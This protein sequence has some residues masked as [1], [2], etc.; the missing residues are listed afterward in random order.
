MEEN[1]LAEL[2]KTS[3][4]KLGISQ[5]ELS[6]RTG[7]DNNSIS[8][9]EKGE[10]RKP[11]SL[12]LVKLSKV[13]NIDL[14]ELMNASGYTEEDI[15]FTRNLNDEDN[16]HVIKYV[17]TI[18]DLIADTENNIKEVKDLIHSIENSMKNHNDEAYK[19]M[20]SEDIVNAD[21]ISQSMIDMNKEILHIYEDK[22][23]SLK[24]QKK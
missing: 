2:V 21:K 3:R 20:S 19:N 10:R 12:S 5:R 4:E 8:Q 18:D 16:K 17:P 11:N 1:K 13:L 23:K 9:I 22:L 7:I 15:N 14:D 6:R 24:K